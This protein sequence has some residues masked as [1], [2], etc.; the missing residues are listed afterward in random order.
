MGGGGGGPRVDR[1]GRG[2]DDVAGL[3]RRNRRRK[4]RHAPRPRSA[5]R[6]LWRRGLAKVL[7]SE[8]LVGRELGRKGIHSTLQRV[9]Q[10]WKLG[11]VRTAQTALVPAA[12]V[13]VNAKV[14]I[15]L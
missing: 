1:G 2:G 15:F 6:G 9:R 4:L 3:Q 12:Q 13:I 10:K 8:E 11:R 7:E 5:R 14:F